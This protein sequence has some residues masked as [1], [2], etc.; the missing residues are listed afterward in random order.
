M[1]ALELHVTLTQQG[2]AMLAAVPVPPVVGRLEIEHGGAEDRESEGLAG[3]DLL[4]GEASRTGNPHADLR[5]SGRAEGARLV[6]RIA[7]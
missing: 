7:P 2:Q 4:A 1:N 5:A 3:D 6:Q